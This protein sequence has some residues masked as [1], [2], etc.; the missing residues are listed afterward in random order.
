MKKVFLTGAA[1]LF[2]ATGT[3]HTQELDIHHGKMLLCCCLRKR[4]DRNTWVCSILKKTVAILEIIEAR[5]KAG[6]ETWITMT[7]AQGKPERILNVICTGTPSNQCPPNVA[8]KTPKDG[9]A[10]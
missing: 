7:G 9:K 10:C 5:S 3:A 4:T 1:A 2:L 6:K 8:G